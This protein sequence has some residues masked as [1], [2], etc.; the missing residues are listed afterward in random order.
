VERTPEGYLRIPAAIARHGMY[1]YLAKELRDWGVPLDVG[2]PNEAIIKVY[3]DPK[4]VF[5]TSSM[6]TFEN[7]PLTKEHP[8]EPVTPNNVNR[9][10]IGMS[11]SPVRALP[12][13]NDIGV[14]I[15]IMSMDGIQDYQRGTRELSA[16]Y[17]STLVM[18]PGMTADGQPYDMRQTKIIGNHIALVER[19]RA[20]TARLLDKETITMA[21][22]QIDLVDHGKVKQQLADSEATIEDLRKQNDEL[23]GENAALK[24]AQLSEEQIK[25]KIDAGV[26]DALVALKQ[27][28]EVFERARKFAPELKDDGKM[29]VKDAM[30]E[31]IKAK[32][33]KADL[34]DKSDDYVRALF[35]NMPEPSAHSGGFSFDTQHT[36]SEV[37]ANPADMLS[38]DDLKKIPMV[39]LAAVD[40]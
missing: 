25:E 33:T 7:K 40:R 6:L 10:M 12:N 29:T 23:K 24:D 26:R 36:D 11:L 9:D 39:G 31:A 3:R 14:D 22:K 34:A 38:F 8:M 5:D 30:I 20:G 35:D 32:G 27:R 2:I 16:G 4:E 37:I 28:G 17:Q 19:G 13:G 18:E 1:D 21:D 15:Q